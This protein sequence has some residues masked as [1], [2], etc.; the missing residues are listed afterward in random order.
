MG[1]ELVADPQLL[2]LDEPTSG[3]DS[4]TAAS[5]IDILHNLAAEGHTILCTIHQP[6]SDMFAQVRDFPNA[7]LVGALTNGL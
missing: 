5:L 6:S 3:L 1:I 2:F 7:C 4:D